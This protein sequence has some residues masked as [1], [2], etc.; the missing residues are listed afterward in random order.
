MI[1]RYRKKPIPVRAM[2]FTDETYHDIIEWT[3]A[4]INYVERDGWDYEDI[5]TLTIPTLRGKVVVRR[6]D[7][8]VKD[9]N[10]NFSTC[11]M[12]VFPTLYEEVVE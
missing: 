9:P 5:Y 3:D 7:Y 1:K 11:P 12:E 4:D 2:Q 10:G 6:G 8:V